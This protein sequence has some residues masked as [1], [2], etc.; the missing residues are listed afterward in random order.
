MKLVYLGA[1]LPK[2]AKHL[3]LVACLMIISQ[4]T[5]RPL[6]GQLAIFLTVVLGA[7]LHSA[8]LAVRRRLPPF[9][10]LSGGGHDRRAS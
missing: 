2:L 9:V 8:G 6:V 1:F 7:L 4:G 5:S 3:A 10:P